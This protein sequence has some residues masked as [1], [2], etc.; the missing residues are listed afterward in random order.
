MRG[1]QSMRR[2]A[3][4]RPLRAGSAVLFSI[5]FA[6]ASA[7]ADE[8]APAVDPEYA[9]YQEVLGLFERG[10]A[11]RQCERINAIAD[12]LAAFTTSREPIPPELVAELKTSRS[13]VGVYTRHLRRQL[14][15]RAR[16]VCPVQPAPCQQPTETSISA[17]DELYTLAADSQYCSVVWSAAQQMVAKSGPTAAAHT[18]ELVLKLR[19]ERP[20]CFDQ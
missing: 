11:S 17:I 12:M 14:K 16:E 2:K 7:R 5:A 19:V 10:M 3:V 6:V 18:L 9:A 8:A 1:D 13:D 20:D 15:Q 4:A